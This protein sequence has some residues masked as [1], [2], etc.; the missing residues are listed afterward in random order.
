M[1]LINAQQVV[2][3]DLW[4]SLTGED[5]AE[6]LAAKLEANEALLVPFQ[7]WQTQ[8]DALLAREAG[9]AVLIQGDTDIDAVAA[10]LDH[11]PMIAI[12]FPSFADGRG[13]S[14]ARV[15]RQRLG[16]KGE[17]RAVG[18]VTWDRL[19]YM[20]RCGFDTFAIADDRFSDKIFKAFNEINVCLQGAADDP[21]P[22]YRQ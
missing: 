17:I 5:A 8:K 21:R 9:V 1:P 7:L 20:L 18:D 14:Q 12:D 6:Q 2:E 10:E 19:R 11:L 13:F 4:V 16:F 15:L 3:D 22:I